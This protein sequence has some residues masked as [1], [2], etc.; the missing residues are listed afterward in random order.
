MGFTP[1]FRRR[2]LAFIHGLFACVRARADRPKAR[3]SRDTMAVRTM[4]NPKAQACR[5]VA[6]FRARS[7]LFGVRARLD[8]RKT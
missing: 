3:A 6:A 5:N 8:C 7:D 2:I 1:F 4:G